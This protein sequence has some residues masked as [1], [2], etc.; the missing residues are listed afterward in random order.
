MVPALAVVQ[1]EAVR[2]DLVRNG[3]DHILH[4]PWIGGV[5]VAALALFWA[6]GRGLDIRYIQ[7]HLEGS[8]Y[9]ANPSVL[10]IQ[11]RKKY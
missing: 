3:W 1:V 4:H 11:D 6:I 2:T 10:V 5:L 7:S 8:C 9:L